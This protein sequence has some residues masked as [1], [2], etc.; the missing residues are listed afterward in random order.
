ME[1]S[2]KEHRRKIQRRKSFLELTE[3]AQKAT[4]R[5]L[6]SLCQQSHPSAVRGH[7]NGVGASAE[8]WLRKM[9][10]LKNL[11]AK[12]VERVR[13][14]THNTD[15]DTGDDTDTQGQT[16]HGHRHTHP[17]RAQKKWGTECYTAQMYAA[18]RRRPAH[19]T[20]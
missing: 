4:D 17:A 12:R 13:A 11:S 18:N 6:R 9:R 19:S 15:T 10:R 16:Q 5:A 1:K 14:Q 7:E 20:W 2:I 3:L 8:P